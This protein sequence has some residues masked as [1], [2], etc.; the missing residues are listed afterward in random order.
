MGFLR[1]KAF[2]F[3]PCPNVTRPC[4]SRVVE[5]IDPAALTFTLAETRKR[6]GLEGQDAGNINN[7]HRAEQEEEL[8]PVVKGAHVFIHSGRQKGTYGVVGVGV[9]VICSFVCMIVCVYGL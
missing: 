9:A 6:Q 8:M 3:Q 5:I 4:H 2:K 7:T 1:Q